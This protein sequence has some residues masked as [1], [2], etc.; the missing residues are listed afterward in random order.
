MKRKGIKRVVVSHYV[1]VVLLT[2][3]LAE[4]V[5]LYSVRTFYYNSI[6]SNLS[7]HAQVS[8][9]FY[10]KFHNNLNVLMF[11][12]QLPEVI[13]SF[14]HDNAELQ[15]LSNQGM[16]L[17]ST[18]GFSVHEQ[19]KTKDVKSAA[20]G[21]TSRW[22]G[23]NASTGE[24]VLAVST[25]LEWNGQPIALLRYVTSLEEVDHVIRNLTNIA[26]LIGLVILATVSLISL[27]LANSIV[28]PIN[29]ITA[30]SALMAKGRLDTRVDEGFKYELGDLAKTLNY[31]AQEIVKSDQLKN[32]FIS[33]ISHELRTPLTSIKGWSE[34]ILLGD[35][36]DHEETRTGLKVI[37]KETDRL[38]GLVEELLDFSRLEQ[39]Q[40]ALEVQPVDLPQL[41]NEVVLQLAAKAKSKQVTFIYDEEGIDGPVLIPGDENRLKQVFLNIADN[42]IKFAYSDTAIRVTIT[43]EESGYLGIRI[44]DQG[45]IIPGEHLSR[46]M[47]KFYQ[48]HP[49]GEGT[50]LGLAI[51]SEIVALHSGTLSIT[52]DESGTEVTVRLPGGREEA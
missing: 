14:A 50:G 10:N 11:D 37:S 41:L 45:V 2:L 44:H 16:V 34:T 18:S 9:S 4:S 36:K 39:K 1:L 21:D 30:A 7:N 6:A 38:V 43:E 8:A 25:P 31:M 19:I 20:Q 47:E 26:L 23:R 29:R 22:I 3:I 33:S 12:S 28:K 15:I 5:F 42:A 40:L 17:A 35:M 46:V 32:D 52:S 27:G 13:E 51:C 24:R 49:Q 48:V